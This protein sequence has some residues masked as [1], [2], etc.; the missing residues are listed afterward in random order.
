MRDVIAD[1]SEAEN[2][3]VMALQK[4]VAKALVP[5][6]GKPTKVTTDKKSGSAKVYF[7]SG[8]FD[9]AIDGETV[10]WTYRPKEPVSGTVKATSPADAAWDIVDGFK[11]TYNL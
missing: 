4:E 11:K 5:Y 7:A 6:F 10:K 1:L 8:T 2:P 9:V 3:D